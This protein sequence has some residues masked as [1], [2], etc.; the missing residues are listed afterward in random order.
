M[1]SFTAVPISKGAPDGGNDVLLLGDQA[2]MRA[3]NRLEPKG[4]L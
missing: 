1:V 2:L 4:V 3:L